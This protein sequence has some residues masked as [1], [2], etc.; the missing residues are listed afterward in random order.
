MTYFFMP[1]DNL[2]FSIGTLQQYKMHDFSLFKKRGFWTPG[3]PHPISSFCRICVVLL[4]VITTF[5]TKEKC[6]WIAHR[7]SL[8]SICSPR[9]CAVLQ[10]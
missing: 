5:S 1:L 4:A 3:I 6:V 9:S 7:K 2:L 10:D 8:G